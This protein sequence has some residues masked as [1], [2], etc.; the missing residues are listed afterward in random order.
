VRDG[1]GTF[2]LYLVALY[3]HWTDYR[4]RMAPF[5]RFQFCPC[6]GSLCT[7]ASA[8]RGV[9]N[10]LPPLAVGVAHVPH[11]DFVQARAHLNVVIVGHVCYPSPN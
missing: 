6:R 8:M 11:F 9:V 1:E 3:E 7:C 2:F 4:S 10:P 5:P